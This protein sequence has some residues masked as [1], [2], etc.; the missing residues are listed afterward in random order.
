M[1][2]E[3][4][5]P[6]ERSLTFLLILALVAGLAAATA[7]L[8]L[9]GRFRPEPSPVEFAVSLRSVQGQSLERGLSPAA[10]LRELAASGVTAVVVEERTLADL[11]FRGDFTVLRLS[12]E[13]APLRGT[14]AQ[15]AAARFPDLERWRL[16][17]PGVPV[18]LLLTGHPDL[19]EWALD[20]ARARFGADRVA[21]FAAGTSSGD[22]QVYAVAVRG[23]L[24]PYTRLGLYPPDLEAARGAG[25]RVVVQLQNPRESPHLSLAAALE[26][27]GS[28]EAVA[29]IFDGGEVWGYGLPGGPARAGADLRALDLPFAVDPAAQPAGTA[30]LAAAAGWRGIK[31]QTVWSTG[32]PELFA[33]GVVER[34]A[35]L[36]VAMPGLWQ[37]FKD[38]PA[39]PAGV[40]AAVAGFTRELAAR[41]LEPGPPEPVSTRRPPAWL[42]VVTGWAVLA[43]AA[44]AWRRLG[45]P[46]GLER[47]GLAVLG[48]AALALPV[49]LSSGVRVAI[50]QGLIL[51][52]AVTFPVVALAPVFRAWLEGPSGSHAGPV[53]PARPA[54]AL[55]AVLHAVRTA[56]GAGLVAA[57]GGLLILALGAGP[58]FLLRTFQMPGTKLAL[59]AGPALALYLYWRLDPGRAGSAGAWLAG[60]LRRPLTLGAVVSAV[61]ALGVV[62]L[63]ISRSGN[64]PLVPVSDLEFTLRARL[65][66]LLGVRPRTKEFL[67]GYPA[68]LLGA[69][70]GPTVLK[71]GWGYV[72][73]A[74]AGVG[75]SS[76]LNTF[77]HLHIPAAVSAARTAVG[78]GLGLA[79]GLLAAG[80]LSATVGRRALWP[81]GAGR[82]ILGWVPALVIGLGALFLLVTPFAGVDWPA[83]VGAGSGPRP[84]E[85][86]VDL[87]DLRRLTGDDDTRL[88]S[89]AAE[90]ASVGVTSV[91]L[92]ETTLGDL[93]R[94][95]ADGSLEVRDG[96]E[97]AA[98]VR[99]G[100]AGTLEAIVAGHPEF[101]AAGSYVFLAAGPRVEDIAAR[102]ALSSNG[103]ITLHAR[104]GGTLVLRTLYPREALERASLGF[105]GPEVVWR[106]GPVAGSGLL[107]APRPQNPPGGDPERLASSLD[108]LRA[109]LDRL[110]LDWS[111]AVPAGGEFPGYPQALSSA[112]AVLTGRGLAAGVLLHPDRPGYLGQLGATEVAPVLAY[113][114][115]RVLPV[116]VA[117]PK[118]EAVPRAAS[119]GADLLYVRLSG[120]QDPETV[121]EFA[122]DLSLSL[123]GHGR[124]TGPSRPLRPAVVLPGPLA[125]SPGRDSALFF[126]L[127][128]VPLAGAA[129]AGRALRSGLRGAAL[130]AI[131]AAAG[132]GGLGGRVLLADARAV[133]EL[134]PA[135]VSPLLPL[136]APALAGV[137]L[138]P[139]PRGTP[140]IVPG[141]WWTPLTPGLGGLLVAVGLVALGLVVVA[142][143]LG[144][145]GG[146]V[147]AL[148]L[149]RAGVGPGGQAGRQ[150]ATAAAAAFGG[151]GAA[152]SVATSGAAGPALVAAAALLVGAAGAAWLGARRRS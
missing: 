5:L 111:T 57:A 107:V 97:L 104:V 94:W 151:A 71:R 51:L 64:F 141:W 26:P 135:A 152:F 58:E 147:A 60:L 99:L 105:Y 67:I 102:L 87:G 70:L 56:V 41:G 68:L 127:V 77:A 10:V 37:R 7:G 150:G 116:A 59:A 133:L 75:V 29:V 86:A 21:S 49:G 103:R 114:Y 40:A 33:E 80:L 84:A 96:R 76:V 140:G 65:A 110:G 18:T 115:A 98:R 44:L 22:P 52:G 6:T 13:S 132:I 46:R 118:V 101:E 89:L 149:I 123:A 15:A 129:L 134:S 144:A 53:D 30:E 125:A 88:A 47:L 16:A 19:A 138:W 20:R 23:D 128:L 27:L 148:A 113:A 24:A 93:V 36:L 66:D 43:G 137:L 74:L 39:W 108:E 50:L 90:L 45:L 17:R 82:T 63:Y 106:A 35:P 4:S 83:L 61:A 126:A 34:G 124:P 38:D 55:P 32:R 48:A 117:G 91:G 142:G 1:P 9:D 85:V 73:A 78:L 79:A 11:A 3:R 136:A 42:T 95:S 139:R 8:A 119:R 62:V 130:A 12:G 14:E 122:R 54:L 131:L 31:L 25:L 81:P 72:L 69:W 28:T 145:V 2:A 120:P 146:S 92:A 112:A 121:V 100:L 109:S 143:G